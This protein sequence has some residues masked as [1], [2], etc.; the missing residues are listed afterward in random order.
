MKPRRSARP[1]YCFVSYSSREPQ[2][3]LLL[4]CLDWV[5]REHFEVV[6]TPSCLTSVSW[7]KSGDSLGNAR[8]QLSFWMDFVRMLFSNTE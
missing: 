8:L 5:F 1:P 6:R 2:L 7:I 4:D 3:P